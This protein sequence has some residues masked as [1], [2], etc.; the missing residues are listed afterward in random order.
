MKSIAIFVC[1]FFSLAAGEQDRNLN[2]SKW[3][4]DDKI[5]KSDYQLIKRSKI[6]CSISNDNDYIFINLMV[7]DRAVSERILVQGLAVW[8]NM[9]GKKIGKMGVRFPLGSEHPAG[10]KKQDADTNNGPEDLI[11]QANTIELI[12]FIS[13]QERRFATKNYDN[14]RGSVKYSP[15]GYFYYRLVMPLSKL[16]I[17]NSKRGNGAMPFNLGFE[18]GYQPVSN[19]KVHTQSDSRKVSDQYWIND[20]RLASSK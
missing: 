14:F 6:Y 18:I 2:Q 19:L 15:D 20:V 16:P 7:P 13:E 11:T 9:D 17:R 4:L 10:G 1:L 8:V 5:E 3:H 12:G